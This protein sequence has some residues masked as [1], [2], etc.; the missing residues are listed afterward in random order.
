[1]PQAKA[2]VGVFWNQPGGVA[3]PPNWVADATTVAWASVN[4]GANDHIWASDGTERANFNATGGAVTIDPA[5][6]TAFGVNFITSGYTIGGGTLTWA[7]TG[8]VIHTG[9]VN[10]TISAVIA[11]TG[12][13]LTKNGTGTLTLNT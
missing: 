7:G 8:G 5:G 13:G 10:A 2:Q 9:T 11:D 4:G 6:V 1:M 3:S 12:V